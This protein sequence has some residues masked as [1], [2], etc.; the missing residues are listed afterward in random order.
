MSHHTCAG[1]VDYFKL[2]PEISTLYISTQNLSY[3]ASNAINNETHPE[4]LNKTLS[5]GYNIFGQFIVHDMT[6]NPVTSSFAPEDISLVNRLTNE[7]RS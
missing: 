1:K 3:Y 5:V 2:Y 6:S 4:D 7:I